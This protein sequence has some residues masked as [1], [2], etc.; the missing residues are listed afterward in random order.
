MIY[1]ARACLWFLS[2]VA[3]SLSG[4]IRVNPWGV[5]DVAE[6]V[7]LA[8]KMSEAEK[9]L[10]HEENYHYVSIHDVA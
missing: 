7:N 1:H 5:E 4:A 9:Q 2:L 8:L 3:I 6:A 10:R